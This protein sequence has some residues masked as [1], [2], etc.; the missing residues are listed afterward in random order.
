MEVCATL[1]ETL[2]TKKHYSHHSAGSKSFGHFPSTNGN[3]IS[4]RRKARLAALQWVSFFRFPSL[5]FFFDLGH[6]I[7]RSRDELRLF[8]SRH[9]PWIKFHSLDAVYLTYQVIQEPQGKC[10]MRLSKQE[11]PGGVEITCMNLPNHPPRKRNTNFRN[12]STS[13]VTL[14][15]AWCRW[16]SVIWKSS[17][18]TPTHGHQPKRGFE[19]FEAAGLTSVDNMCVERG[20]RNHRLRQCSLNRNFEF[21]LACLPVCPHNEETETSRTCACVWCV[22]QPRRCTSENTF[23]RSYNYL[24]WTAKY[25]NIA[26]KMLKISSF[27]EKKYVKCLTRQ[28]FSRDSLILA[29]WR[30]KLKTKSKKSTY[31]WTFK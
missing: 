2:E 23:S 13:F 9:Q 5:I 20:G 17:A 29:N 30:N 22:T 11:V 8:R 1:F 18:A 27:L 31:P 4:Q 24:K 6:V 19:V 3:S 26:R 25:R 7:G 12:E 14:S 21:V 16:G 15:S 10:F 28:D